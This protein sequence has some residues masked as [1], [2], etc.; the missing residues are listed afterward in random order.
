M[1]LLEGHTAPLTDMVTA[2]DGSVVV[3]A[4]EDGTARVWDL[5]QP[6]PSPSQ[7]PASLL[8]AFYVI[9]QACRI[10]NF[11]RKNEGGG[12]FKSRRVPF[13]MLAPQA[14]LSAS[15]DTYIHS[16][17][18]TFARQAIKE[19]IEDVLLPGKRSAQFSV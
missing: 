2:A 19:I 15:F 5:V 12:A 16:S 10:R 18:K 17:I 14:H 8:L 3:T 11:K 4:S 13:V 6:S 9:V 7:L 1:L